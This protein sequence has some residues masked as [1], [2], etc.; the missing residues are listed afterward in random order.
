MQALT[1]VPLAGSPF[2]A[3][4]HQ[5][6]TT[7]RITRDAKQQLLAAGRWERPLTVEEL[8]AVQKL[9]ERLQMGFI[10]VVD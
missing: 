8:A 1:T 10:R 6:L 9:T 4:I 2:Q 5:I 3:T 7:G